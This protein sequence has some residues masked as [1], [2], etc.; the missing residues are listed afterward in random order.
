MTRG[1]GSGMAELNAVLIS[2]CS[3]RSSLHALL[4]FYQ[5]LA[6]A[7][8][9]AVLVAEILH[10]AVVFTALVRRHVA[11][12]ARARLNAAAMSLPLSNCLPLRMVPTV[13]LFS[14]HRC[15]AHQS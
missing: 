3:P 7:A 1:A 9:F 5:L 10:V 11:D 12:A 4:D 15:T 8:V 14:R 2:S 6:D 13:C